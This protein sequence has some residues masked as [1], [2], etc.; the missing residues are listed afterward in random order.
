MGFIYF[1]QINLTLP[2]FLV[3][4]YVVQEKQKKKAK[5]KR[6]KQ[7]SGLFSFGIIDLVKPEKDDRREHTFFSGIS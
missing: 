5:K 1:F 6:K 7:L 2:F 4:W 3:I